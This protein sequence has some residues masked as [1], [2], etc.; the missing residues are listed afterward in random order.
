[1]IATA[2]FAALA[3]P[4]VT[5][6]YE[7]WHSRNNAPLTKFS[8]APTKEEAEKVAANLRRAGEQAEVRGPITVPVEDDQ[9]SG[10]KWWNKHG[11]E[12]KYFGSKQ[13]SDMSKHAP[14][15]DQPK[16]AEFQAN[17]T[18]FHSALKL[19]KVYDAKGKQVASPAVKVNSTFRT[20]ERQYLMYHAAMISR[21]IEDPKDVKSWPGVPI[22]WDHGDNAKSVRAARDMAVKIFGTEDPDTVN[23]EWT[24][25]NPI[26]KPEKGSNHAR[27]LAVDMTVRWNGKMVIRVPVPDPMRM[28]TGF[29]DVEIDSGPF[30]EMNK[31]LWGVAMEYFNVKKHPTDKPHWSVDGH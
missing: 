11:T 26:A 13:F 25:G 31:D 12:A 2:L 24:D 16:S 19:A 23:D 7:V 5:T 28:R 20:V 1:M 3:L 4:N 18:A 15:A 8:D 10:M 17:I 6:K 9:L 14:E 21:G 30:T 27:G 29:K 22:K